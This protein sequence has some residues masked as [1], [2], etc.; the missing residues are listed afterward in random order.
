MG[1]QY[2]LF[3][4]VGVFLL[5]E[6]QCSDEFSTNMQGGKPIKIVNAHKTIK[7]VKVFRLM[8]RAHQ[9]THVCMFQV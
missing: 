6:G 2:W 4:A 8:E 7:L 9:L 1:R 3:L 5:F